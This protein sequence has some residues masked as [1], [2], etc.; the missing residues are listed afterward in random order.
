M[1]RKIAVSA[2]IAALGLT[3]FNAY[4][5]ETAQ[6]NVSLEVTAGCQVYVGAPS[7]SP[8]PSQ[9]SLDFGALNVFGGNSVDRTTVESQTGS[10]AAGDAN[11]ISVACGTGSSALTPVLTMTSGTNDNGATRNLA[12]GTNRIPYTVHSTAARNAASLIQNG[13]TVP[14]VASGGASTA[15]LYGKVTAPEA[16]TTAGTYTDTLLLTL[17]Y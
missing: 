13:D 12:S 5:A 14:L 17:S 1:Y 3:G 8:T 10:G 6:V 11:V 7:A 16:V 9:V 2:I 15:V 4:G